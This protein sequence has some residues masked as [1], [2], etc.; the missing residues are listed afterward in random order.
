MLEPG[1]EPAKTAAVAEA[2]PFPAISL[3]TVCGI[4]ELEA[5]GSRGVTDVLSI[6][7]PAWPDP[8]AFRRWGSHRRTTLY[9]NDAILP[10]P[11]TVLPAE[12][13][14][15]AILAFG[16]SLGDTA[17]DQRHLLV[18]CH[19]G[20]SRSTAALAM[21]LA[22]A[23]PEVAEDRVL[24]HLLAIRPQAWPNSRMIGLADALLGRGGRLSVAARRLYGRQLSRRPDLAGIMREWN[25]AA[26]VEAAIF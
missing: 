14:I 19:F 2:T 5:H 21:L 15:A 13:D 23:H 16:R 25:R 10:E 17:A 3:Q 26:E 20:I 18:H 4:E 8:E 22:Q 6:L 11:A 24:E 7:D 9:F 1:T 12:E